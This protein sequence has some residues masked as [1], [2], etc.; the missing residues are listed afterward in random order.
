MLLNLTKFTTGSATIGLGPEFNAATVIDIF[1]AAEVT[2][3]GTQAAA[4]QLDNNGYPTQS[5]TGTI[6]FSWSAASFTAGAYRFVWSS[7]TKGRWT[8]LS[9]SGGTAFGTGGSVITSGGNQDIVVDGTGAGYVDINLTGLSVAMVGTGSWGAAGTASTAFMLASNYTA[10]LSGQVYTTDFIDLLKDLNPKTIRTMGYMLKGNG[11]QNNTCLWAYATKTTD[12][13]WFGAHIRGALWSGGYG[14]NGQMTGQDRMTAAPCSAFPGASWTANEMLQAVMVNKPTQLNVSGV[15]AK[16][17]ANAGKCQVTTSSTATM[18]AGDLVWFVFVN[19]TTE[20]NGVQTILSVDSGTTFTVDVTFVNA[21]TSGGVIGTQTITVS[22]RTGAKFIASDSGVPLYANFDTHNAGDLVTMVYDSVLDRVVLTNGGVYAYV[23]IAVQCGLANAIKANLHANIPWLADD[24]Y[25]TNWSTAALNALD[26]NLF[27]MPEY[28]NEV[29]WSFQF[30]AT[31]WANQRSLALGLSGNAAHSYYALRVRMVMGLIGT[32][33][34]GRT[35]RLRR[36]L[37]IQAAGDTT[38][39]S[40]RMKG[41]NLAPSGTGTGGLG[42]GNSVYNT[43]TG[44]ADYT[45]KPNRPIDLCESIS[46]ANYSGGCQLHFGADI[47][48]GTALNA[49]ENAIWYQALV[50]AWNANDKATVY[51][52]IDADVTN[53]RT[54]VNKVLGSGTTF[55]VVDSGNTPIDKGWTGIHHV[56]FEVTGGSGYDG[57]STSEIYRATSTGTSTFTMTSYTNGQLIGGNINAGTAG[58]GTMTVGLN[59]IRTMKWLNSLWYGMSEW[60]AAQMD[61]DRPAGMANVRVDQYEGGIELVGAPSA[62]QYDTAGITSPN[63]TPSSGAAVQVVVDAA[64]LDWKLNGTNTAA[65]FKK[66]FEQFMGL[67]PT[68]KKGYGQ[69]PHHKS[70]SLLIFMGQSVGTYN[71]INGEKPSDTKRQFFYGFKNFVGTP[72]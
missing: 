21:Y 56:S 45:A 4:A 41:Q 5:F 46:P 39:L 35:N 42:Q 24:D 16:T 70:P 40:Y 48:L 47:A 18:T 71:L 43:F 27:F 12:L 9:A 69:F 13:S 6:G 58:T 63:G 67:D 15:V 38:T 33:W 62:S 17:G 28:G 32:A 11:S 51:A 66:Y 49:A 61:G 26:T 53:G 2:I 1:K 8:F 19:G 60:L 55:T 54:L 50:D 36:I 23:P 34:S 65:T 14:T 29:G 10:W 3:S 31:Q 25:V 22:G 68:M 52:M 72:S 44:S 7:G 37:A 64:I 20:I 59:D 30:P 57:V